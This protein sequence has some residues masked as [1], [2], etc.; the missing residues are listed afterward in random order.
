MYQGAM[1]AGTEKPK[2]REPEKHVVRELAALSGNV[3]AFEGCDHVVIDEEGRFVAQLC[4]IEAAEPGGQRFNPAMT[5][6]ERRRP[7]N[8]MFMCLRH[9]VVTNDVEAWPVE[10]LRELKERHESEFR[11]QRSRI[12]EAAIADITMAVELGQPQ[13]M[14]RFGAFIDKEL[15][16]EQHQ[17]TL[18]DFVRPMLERL[19][20]LAPQ[21]RS[22]FEIVVDRGETHGRDLGLRCA[23]LEQV[24]GLGPDEIK[25]QVGTM[26]RY[27][28]AYAARVLPGDRHRPPRLHRRTALRPAR[29]LAHPRPA[30]SICTG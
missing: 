28:I 15:T 18:E 29:R 2:R 16:A 6:E 27:R 8:L 26:A 30:G 19:R 13:N 7:S 17:E 25:P 24:T 20:R 22:L 10:R 21:T 14:L 4:H 3:C 11:G 1:G 12:P 9:H 23:E 5:N